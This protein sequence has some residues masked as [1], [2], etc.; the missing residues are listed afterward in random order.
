MRRV[1]S[2]LSG[3]T[4][5]A[6]VV[7]A[8]YAISSSGH[9][10]NAARLNSNEVSYVQT[11]PFVV[12]LKTTAPSAILFR[13]NVIPV[14]IHGVDLKRFLQLAKEFAVEPRAW[15]EVVTFS[16]YQKRVRAR[17]DEMLLPTQQMSPPPL[18]PDN[19]ETP[20]GLRA[21]ATTLEAMIKAQA[22]AQAHA[23]K[24]SEER[25]ARWNEYQGML[26][27]LEESLK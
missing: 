23:K 19:N 26:K 24:V 21:R 13:T 18:P 20:E 10:N 25:A 6:F 27:T 11:V 16:E 22:V 9:T 14:A 12:E 5:V 4:Y 1:L 2:I 8:I 7:T 17:H 15:M 3:C